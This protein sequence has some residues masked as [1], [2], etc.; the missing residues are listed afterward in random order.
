MWCALLYLIHNPG[1]GTSRTG[2]SHL[3]GPFPETWEQGVSSVFGS[4]YKREPAHLVPG[5]SAVCVFTQPVS[6]RPFNK[7]ELHGFIY[8]IYKIYTVYNILQFQN[9]YFYL[10]SQQVHVNYIAAN[11]IFAFSLPTHPY[12]AFC[13]KTA[14]CIFKL[15]VV[16]FSYLCCYNWSII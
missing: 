11:T 13:Y 6:N 16:W 5:Q 4:H 9:P 7:A 10:L 8:G 15:C 12:L 2:L 3:S 1:D 14:V